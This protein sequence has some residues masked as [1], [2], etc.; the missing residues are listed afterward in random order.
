MIRD[1]S[2]YDC[3]VHVLWIP[4]IERSMKHFSTIDG[5]YALSGIFNYKKL[6][7]WLLLV[8]VYNCQYIIDEILLLDFTSCRD[9]CVH[10]L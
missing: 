3:I 4:W 6:S 7:D 2:A 1:S 10:T 8:V 5:L 9:A